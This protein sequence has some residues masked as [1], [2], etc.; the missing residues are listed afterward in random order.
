MEWI[1]CKKID[2]QNISITNPLL[3][4]RCIS[5]IQKNK[6]TEG[7]LW[8]D[9]VTDELFAT[10]CT[11]ETDDKNSAFLATREK[12]LK[13]GDKGRYGVSSKH[14][15]D[16]QVSISDSESI[17][18]NAS[19]LQKYKNSKVL[20]IGAGPT[21]QHYEREWKSNLD[22]YDY[23]WSC[24]HFFKADFLKGVRIDLAT[25]GNEVEFTDPDLL[26]RISKDNTTI[27]IETTI[28]RNKDSF[29]T[30]LNKYDKKNR[31]FF[32]TRYFGKIGSIPRMLAASVQMGAKHVSFVGVD[33]IPPKSHQEKITNS[34]FQRNKKI[35]GPSDYDSYRRQY[36]MLWDYLLNDLDS[37][38]NVTFYNYG[39]EYEFNM[40]KN[41]PENR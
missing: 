2:L 41:I 23:V 5:Y 27:G 40:T 22:N 17:F 20:I 36:V 30:F 13:F 32:S 24:N 12:Y 38:K 26:A 14:Y 15:V 3:F 35:T 7:N 31:F 37:D 19:S 25:L 34:V 21:A 9:G 1:N 28:S 18:T 29:F 39:K 11:Y 10:N 8:F 6:I 33:G 4:E 16:Q